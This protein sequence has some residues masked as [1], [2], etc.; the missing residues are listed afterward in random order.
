[1]TNNKKLLGLLGISAV[2]C[3]MSFGGA[4]KAAPLSASATQTLQAV[5]G[6]YLDITA[7]TS[8]TTLSTTIAPDT[9]NLAAQLV[10]KFS[11]TLNEDKTLYLKATTE[12]VATANENA[13]FQKTGTTYIILS[14]IGATQKPTAA[15][16]A[17]CKATAPDPTIN[18]NAI[19]YPLSGVALT[20]SSTATYDGTKNQYTIAA[21]RGVS[22]ATTTIDTPVLANTYSYLDTAGTYQAILTLSSTSL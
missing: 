17:D 6:T 11:I 5:L 20:N 19:A 9:G 15:A 12:S 8:G 14:N 18:V 7:V 21:K 3:I 22:I 4:A 16:V 13:F 10:S 2:M 1:M